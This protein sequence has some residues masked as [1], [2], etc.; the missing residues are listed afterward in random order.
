MHCGQ[1][2]RKANL[3]HSKATAVVHPE[4]RLT[5]GQVF[6]R[7]CQLVNALLDLG[8]RPRDRVALLASDTPY[9]LEQVAGLAMGG[10]VRVPLN[11][12]QPLELHLSV[13]ERVDARV[14]ITDRR[15][16]DQLKPHLSRFT[17]LRHIVL[18]DQAPRAV[19]G[20]EVLDYQD[21]IEKASP[22]DARVDVRVDDVLHVSFTSGTTGVPKGIVLTHGRWLGGTAEHMILLPRLTR[23]DRYLSVLPLASF[24]LLTFALMSAGAQFV[25]PAGQD[26]RLVARALET[27]QITCTWIYP[28]M[29]QRIAGEVRKGG[30][31]AASLRAVCTGGGALSPASLEEIVEALGDV[32][33]LGFGMTESL[34]ATMLT[35]DE[36]RHGIDTDAPLLRSVGRPVFGSAVRIQ[37]ETG[38][39]C[40][41]GRYGDLLIDTPGTMKELWKDSDGTA[42]RITEDGFVRTGDVGRL[43]EDGYLFVAGRKEDLIERR[44]EVFSPV[45]IE[46]A[47]SDHPRV[48]EAAVVVPTD[49]EDNGLRVIVVPEPQSSEI[50]EQLLRWCE[51]RLEPSRV[52]TVITLREDPLPRT[53][54]GKL[55]RAV[56]HRQVTADAGAASATP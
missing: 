9:A 42:A 30:Y 7:A 55:Q 45:E 34:P 36:V 44:G 53:F 2:V 46:E 41:V 38:A 29:V 22:E 49:F 21:L 37:S 27:E 33:Y 16:H 25:S 4:R 28:T 6:E 54:A 35:P 5:Y 39:E 17:S 40:P 47:L 10:F 14:L 1:I 11:E 15:H 24:P 19:E 23:Q 48:V 31:S 12:H 51:E 3:F 56:L 52:P 13:L 8:T 50:E 43:D 20:V 32:L 26:P 18:V